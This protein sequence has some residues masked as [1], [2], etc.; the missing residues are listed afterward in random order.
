MHYLIG[1]LFFIGV[2][3]GLAFLLV[4]LLIAMSGG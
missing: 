2:P 3:V 4:K 1:L